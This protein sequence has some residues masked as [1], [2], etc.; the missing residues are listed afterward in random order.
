[1]GFPIGAKKMACKKWYKSKTVWFNI[2][3][4]GIA[5]LTGLSSVLPILSPIISEIAMA[6]ILFGVGS[7]NVVLRAVTSKAIV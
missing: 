4:I 5:I 3:T 6:Y 1:M 2:A 7:V